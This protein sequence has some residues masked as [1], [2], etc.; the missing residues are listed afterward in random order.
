M[1][2]R[3]PA[4]QP[5]GRPSPVADSDAATRASAGGARCGACCCCA[6]ARERAGRDSRPAGRFAAPRPRRPRTRAGHH[7]P[8]SLAR[9][10]PPAEMPRAAPLGGSA[11]SSRAV[12]RPP[13]FPCE[14]V[15]HGVGFHVSPYLVVGRRPPRGGFFVQARAGRALRRRRAAR[16]AP[17]A[18][19]RHTRCGSA[20]L[21]TTVRR[22]WGGAAPRGRRGR[23]RALRFRRP[24]AP[25]RRGAPCP[26]AAPATRRRPSTRTT[27]APFSL[28]APPL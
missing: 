16:G 24:T 21:F 18:H 1:L 11:P 9:S 3:S 25:R 5:P 4:A 14:S 7:G 15:D 13:S 2:F 26:P 27:P 28:S 19:N 6:A 8:R 10:R 23:G 17:P 20:T 12:H 22:G